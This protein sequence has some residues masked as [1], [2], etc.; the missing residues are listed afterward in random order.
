MPIVIG[1]LNE[2]LIR[3]CPMRTAA[4]VSQSAVEM[5]RVLACLDEELVD[6]GLLVV[7]DGAGSSTRD[8][9]DELRLL[10]DQLCT[11][12][13]ALGA[14][15]RRVDAIQLLLTPFYHVHAPT[16]SLTT[17]HYVPLPYLH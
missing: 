7:L 3:H 15:Q 13:F 11:R 1:K 6:G 10:V 2:T 4:A 5:E 12:H 14:R 9:A 8:A 17:T 16:S